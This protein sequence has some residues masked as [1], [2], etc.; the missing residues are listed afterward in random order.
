MCSKRYCNSKFQYFKSRFLEMGKKLK[1]NRVRTTRKQIRVYVC[2]S[3]TFW[4]YLES[5]YDFNRDLINAVERGFG[6][7]V[8]FGCLCFLSYS[9][10]IWVCKF[11]KNIVVVRRENWR[12]CITYPL[13]QGIHNFWTTP[14]AHDVFVHSFS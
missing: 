7:L 9:E 10:R 3:G 14:R 12:I 13:N 4:L 1:K 2:K 5:K 11:S 6:M 8:L